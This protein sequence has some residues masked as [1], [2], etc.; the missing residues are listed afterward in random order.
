MQEEIKIVSIGNHCAD[1]L[2]LVY[3]KVYVT[4]NTIVF[5]LLIYR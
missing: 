1:R 2:G 5:L 4:Q 3:I